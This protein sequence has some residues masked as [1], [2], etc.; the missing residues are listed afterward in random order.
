MN[1]EERLAAIE[2]R[3]VTMASLIKVQELVIATLAATH[4]DKAKLLEALQNGAAMVEAGH[5]FD[6]QVTDERREQVQ[7]Y[8]RVFINAAGQRSPS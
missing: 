2:R 3:Q 8:M 1:T 7:K 6:G 4:P 5:L